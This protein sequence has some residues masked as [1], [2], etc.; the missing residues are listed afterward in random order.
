[1]R[2]HAVEY[3]RDEGE[4]DFI[5]VAQIFASEIRREQSLDS[6]HDSQ[7][8][9]LGWEG[10]KEPQLLCERGQFDGAICDLVCETANGATCSDGRPVTLLKVKLS[11]SSIEC[12]K[13]G[14]LA[15]QRGITREAV[16]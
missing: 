5:R 13:L 11:K 15:S 2:A 4:R 9:Y 3:Q 8:A 10:A 7:R 1:L 12:K 16:L 14:E 6:A